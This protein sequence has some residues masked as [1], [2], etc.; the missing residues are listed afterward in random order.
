MMNMRKTG[1]EKQIP[2]S[3]KKAME[4]TK[5]LVMGPLFIHYAT[6]KATYQRE[7]NALVLSKK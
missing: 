1:T 6:N 3:S 4:R 2:E 7:I 5:R